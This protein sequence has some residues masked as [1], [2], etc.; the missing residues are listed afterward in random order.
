M[1]AE[2]LHTKLLENMSTAVILLDGG[3]HLSH[4]NTAAEGLLG[5]SGSR[6]IGE[7]IGNLLIDACKSIAIF[8]ETLYTGQ[9]HTER[10]ATFTTKLSSELKHVTV[11][12]TVSPADDIPGSAL[13][14]ELQP[15]DRLLRINRE[16]NLFWSQESN[17][18]L[19]KG[20][21]HEIKNPLGGIRGAAQLLEQDLADEELIEYTQ[22]I[23]NEADR[24][25]KLVDRMLGPAQPLKLE[26]INIHEV[27][28]RVRQLIEAENPGTIDIQR[29]YDPSIPDLRADSSRLIQAVLN[30]TRNAV[31]ALTEASEYSNDLT[32]S[33]R[34]ILKSR[35]LRHFT[36]GGKQH[37]LVCE[38]TVTDN[39]PGIPEQIRDQI[40]LPM[41]SGHADNS[42]LG[43]PIAQ[44]IANQHRGLIT[45]DSRPGETNFILYLPIE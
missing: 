40:F 41:V 43:L 18:A 5:L 19:L 24:L 2:Q 6:N 21:A 11:D 27:F 28:E 30:V 45:C 1:I 26:M 33:P 38:L 7:N 42:G 9:P 31:K 17:T 4:I 16:G 22:I 12:Y 29:D 25:R 23:I 36:I 13:L 35:V 14:I 3:L 10:E 37:K 34:I 8:Q 44:S 15:I 39:G 32:S 20:L